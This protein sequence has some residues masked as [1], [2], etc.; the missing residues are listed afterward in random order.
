MYESRPLE[1][2]IRFPTVCSDLSACA[3]ERINV[4]QIH[5]RRGKVCKESVLII[6]VCSN[7]GVCRTSVIQLL[8]GME[9]ALLAYEIIVIVVVKCG[10]SNGI[11]R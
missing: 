5:H 9:K 4:S 11:Q 6:A 1:A 8:V 10:W 3:S 7:L 2:S